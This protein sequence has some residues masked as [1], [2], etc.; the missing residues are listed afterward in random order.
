M[1]SL[2]VS[3]DIY[4]YSVDD[5]LYR[6]QQS[7]P[8]LIEVNSGG[9]EVFSGWQL[10]N[11][12]NELGIDTIC[13]GL[14]GSIASFILL[15]GKKVTMMQNSML[16]IHKAS[17]YNYGNADYLEKM[18]EDLKIIDNLLADFYTNTILKR[19]GGDVKE[20]KKK[21][22]KMM[23][24]ETFIEPQEALDLGL[25]DDIKEQTIE[26][27]NKYYTNFLNSLNPNNKMEH[28][29][30]DAN[31]L[32]NHLADFFRPKNETVTVEPKEV[33]G[34]ETSTLEATLQSL[35]DTVSKLSERIGT[36]ENALTTK[37][38]EVENLK[39][40]NESLK[41]EKT[42]LENSLQEA[43]TKVEVLDSMRTQT[44][45]HKKQISNSDK[46]DFEEF[47]KGL[48]YPQH[49][50]KTG[51]DFYAKQQYKKIQESQS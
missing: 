41:S 30:K 42:N 49:L 13:T 39:I 21:I 3:G 33:D 47:K 9:G 15:S 35:N 1:S 12:I 18:A 46:N 10:G 27:S 38:S 11:K 16:M 23:E 44:S 2:I 26:N 40:E 29:R 20:V 51:R 8:S 37:E 19:K 24:A 50:S 45:N 48:S 25:I 31:G 28:N 32:L 17:V 14:A 34:K 6:I 7:K 22:V 36:L 43:N 4:Q 5:I